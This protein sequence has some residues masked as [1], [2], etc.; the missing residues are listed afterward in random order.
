MSEAIEAPVEAVEN[1]QSI[2]APV[3]SEEGAEESHEDQLKAAAE[4]VL[5]EEEPSEEE[6]IEEEGEES[7]E[8]SEEEEESDE[9][10]KELKKILKLK[11]NGKE[12]EEEIDFNDEEGLKRKLQKAYSAEQKWQEAANLRKDVEVFIKEMQTNP[13][14]IMEQMGMNVEEVVGKYV[15]DKLVEMQ[16]TPEQI[17]QEKVQKELEDLREQKK[18]MEDEAKE[19]EMQQMRDKYAQEI[20]NEIEAAITSRNNLPK[21]PYVVRRM[22]DTWSTAINHGL[23]VSADQVLEVVEQEIIAELN[24][25]FNTVPEDTFEAV[26]EKVLGKNNLNRMRKNRVA[27]AKKAPQSTKSIKETGISAQNRNSTDEEK[28]QTVNDFFKGIGRL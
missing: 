21:S 14:A 3:V 15:D 13:F 27:K 4:E 10:A 23:E 5:G 2:E 19:R 9:E 25:M 17:E 11:V 6:A 26:V 28:A 12:I 1:P 8:E 7:E 24:D 20:E 16:K 18:K 22:A